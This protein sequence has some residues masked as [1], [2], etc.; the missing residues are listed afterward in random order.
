MVID[1]RLRPKEAYILKLCLDYLAIR[2]DCFCWRNNNHAVPI[3]M[4]GK[5]RR[6]GRHSPKGISD[7][8]GI[9][10]DGRMIAIE[11]KRPGAKPTE[12]QGAFLR[13]V[14]NCGGIAFVA[15]SVEEV[16]AGL[17]RAAQFPDKP[18]CDPQC[19]NA[20]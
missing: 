13:I 20:V 1:K 3:G 14:Q 12:D 11:I 6:P 9:F 5:F 7:I 10:S 2:S 8:L 17:D 15:T 19:K 16:R 4:T 18:R